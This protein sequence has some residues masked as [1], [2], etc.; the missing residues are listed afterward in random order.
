MTETIIEQ[1]EKI[2]A[3]HQEVIDKTKDQRKELNEQI[4]SLTQVTSK[5]E[6]SWAGEWFKDNYNVYHQNFNPASGK[7]MQCD[8]DDIKNDLKK[9]T[10]ISLED[11][12]QKIP[13]LSKAFF[14]FKDFIL[15]ELS[16]L[17]DLEGYKQESEILDQIENFQ[18]GIDPGEYIKQRR[19]RY[20]YV[21]DPTFINKGINTPPHI[22]VGGEIVFTFSILTSYDNFEKLSH[23]LIRQLEIKTSAGDS[24]EDN[25][26]TRPDQLLQSIIEKFHTVSTQLLNRYNNKSTLEITDEYDVQDLLNA[27][28]RIHFEDVRKEE[29]TP[30]YAGGST[31]VDFLLKREQTLI[32]VK[33]TRNN[34][35]DKE[36]GNQLILDV[37][38]YKSHPDC[39]KL[40]CFV[41]DP[42]NLIVN[43]RGLEDDLNRL[44]TEEMIVEVYIRP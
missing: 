37:A 18:W 33:K 7:G 9:E 17:K 10:G 38:H 16:I 8:E 44:T 42:D 6:E 36:V 3:K 11:I 32:E 39:K 12:R 23:R 30:S 25:L 19:P 29:Y 2:K 22:A 24:S 34:L 26:S 1:L 15:S 41:Y 14:E 28:L 20:A 27:L 43:P 4:E 31:R 5:Y 35:K 13:A 21:T 40:I